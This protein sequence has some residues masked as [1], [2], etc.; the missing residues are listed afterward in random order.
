MDITKII[1]IAVIAI[2]AILYIAWKIYK[3]GL[4][5]TAIDFI[6]E[7]EKAYDNGGEKKKYVI[8]Q[9]QKIIPFP[10]SLFV[11]EKI[12]DQFMEK[13]FEEIKD[14]LHYKPELKEGE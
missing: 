2:V 9:L 13:V 5:C 11:N 10:F 4:R 1:A 7:A 3:S 12:I 8:E 14:A 6:V